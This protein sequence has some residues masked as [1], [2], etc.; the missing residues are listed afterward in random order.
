MSFAF[1]F[2]SDDISDDEIVQNTPTTK[3]RLDTEITISTAIE[4]IQPSFV[5][6]H[7]TLLSL[8]N[9][10]ISFDQY[11]TPGGITVYRRQLFDVKHQIMVEDHE[12]SSNIIHEI[13]VG[14]S[15]ELDLKKDVY[16][17]G[18]KLWEC[19][20]DL[21]DLINNYWASNLLNYKCYFELGCG[22]ALPTCH[23]LSKMLLA[24]VNSIQTVIA[25]D[26]NKEVLRLVT[27]PNMV[28][29]WAMTL[30]PEVLHA[31]MDPSIPLNDGEIIFTTDL[32]AEFEKT[33]QDARIDLRLIHGSW[34]PSFLDL[35]SPLAPDLIVTSETIY[36]ME[37]LP[38]VI[39]VILHFLQK[40]E[41]IGLVAAKE[42]YF[43]V[44][45]SIVEFMQRLLH[46]KISPITVDTV[47][48]N[49]GQLKRDIVQ[50]KHG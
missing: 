16:E 25:S 20:Y 49:S 19:S 45:G 6:V 40:S 26:F 12:Y 34:G 23:L 9:V 10:R 5:S 46:R 3:T 43:G 44:G 27:V 41:S 15:D 30:H 31:F 22:T 29:A 7:E 37:S 39:D 21:V 36:S 33:L 8:A 42:Y 14:A 48:K 2:T 17:G 11:T 28:I 24:L 13:L 50:I 38:I 47:G 32:I 18:F 35:V 4:L 1:G